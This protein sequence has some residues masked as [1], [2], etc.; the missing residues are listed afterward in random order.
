ML[1]HPG[2]VSPV[3]STYRLPRNCFCFVRESSLDH[4][5]GPPTC[6]DRLMRPSL[7]NPSKAWIQSPWGGP[8]PDPQVV[9]PFLPGVTNLNCSKSCPIFPLS[10][11]GGTAWTTVAREPDGLF[12]YS[13]EFCLLKGWGGGKKSPKKNEHFL[14]HGHYMKFKFQRS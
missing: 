11:G 13:W 12:S 1:K 3:V 2:R 5:F 9:S 7:Q 4:P 6:S 8:P 14:T 10:Q